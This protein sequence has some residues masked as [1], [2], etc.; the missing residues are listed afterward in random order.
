MKIDIDEKPVVSVIVPVKNVEH[1]LEALLSALRAQ[2]Y[3]KDKTQIIIVD[4]GSL[5]RTESILTQHPEILFARENHVPGS[6]AA[7]N[8]GL[9]LAVGD[10]IAFT[11]ADCRPKPDWIMRGVEAL[12][13]E[14]A[15]L[16][17]GR[18]V[19]TVSDRPTTSELIDAS[20]FMQNEYNIKDRR[21]AVTA[22]LFVRRDVFHSIGLFEE[23]RSGGDYLWTKKATSNGFSLIYAPEAIV[24]HPAR[25]F[26]ALMEKSYRVGSGFVSLLPRRFY[27]LRVLKLVLRLLTPIPSKVIFKLAR[28]HRHNS[29]IKKG[30]F[31]FWSIAYA[32]QLVEAA[33]VIRSIFKKPRS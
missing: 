11:D 8:K 25:R 5:D 13:R 21:T 28:E 12:V 19:F 18:V 7:R 24:H 3:P 1:L 6:Y 14:G 31:S 15:A 27:A 16:A 10:V 32:Y 30:Y 9:S 26:R 23:V 4:N 29:R 20:V 33:A 22:N 2:N 17:G